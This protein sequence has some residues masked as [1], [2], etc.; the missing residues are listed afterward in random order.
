[1]KK[2]IILAVAVSVMFGL[3]ACGSKKEAAPTNAAAG[4]SAAA[5][6]EVK[7]V[8]TNFKFDQQEYKVKAGSDVKLSLENK[9]GIHGIEV[10]GLNVKLDGQNLS[11][12]F[13]A[14]KAGTYEIICNVPCG[15]GHMQMKAKL[16]VE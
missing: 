1:M 16:V 2:V 6:S 10:K 7:L 12:T 14:E 11:K 3:S 5:A 13:K 4:S 9:E 8:A 15:T